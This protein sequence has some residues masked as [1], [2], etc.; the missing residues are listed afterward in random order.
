MEAATVK[1]IIEKLQELQQDL[2]CYVRPKYFGTMTYVDSAPIN[3]NGIC[4]MEEFED[5]VS[6]NVTF[7][8]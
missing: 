7:L 3:L 5:G 1:E 8:I 2:P 4:E 6:S